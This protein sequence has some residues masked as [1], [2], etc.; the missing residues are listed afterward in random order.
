MQIHTVSHIDHWLTPDHLNFI[1]SHFADRTEFFVET[2]ELPPDLSALPC[3]LHGPV[4]GDAPV[5]ESEVTYG[6]RGD[7]SYN[8]R[9]VDRPA[10]PSRLMTVVAGFYEGAMV[11]YTA[12][13]GP[14]A[15]R[16][17]MSPG[18]TRSD[19]VESESFWSQHALS[20]DV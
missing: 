8:S 3:G 13:G 10:R 11:L 9:L 14:A 17:V 19:V 5:V 12:Y 15:P 1:L 18:L 2:V 20:S 4:I 16:E 6:K 7:R